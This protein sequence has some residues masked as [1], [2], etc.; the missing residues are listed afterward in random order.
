MQK[1]WDSKMEKI[2]QFMLKEHGEILGLLLKLEKEKQDRNGAFIKFKEK[3]E[4]HMFAEEKAIFAF[5]AENKKFEVLATIMQQHTEIENLIKEISNLLDHKENFTK[6]IKGIRDLT[7][8]HVTLEDTKFYPL[9]DKHLTPI[10]QENMLKR[11]KEVIL[12]NIR[13]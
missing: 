9:L 3:Q 1:N 6:Q 2:S 13:G 4:N 5:Y 11:V 7:K 8:K 10:Q 12:G